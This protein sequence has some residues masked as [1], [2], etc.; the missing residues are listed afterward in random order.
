[1]RKVALLYN[2]FAGTRRRLRQTE[3]G[4]A[5]RVFREHGVEVIP[6][7]TEGPG[8]AGKQALAAIAAGADAIIC[9]GGDGTVHEAMQPL[10]SAHSRTPLGVIPLGTGNG[11]ACEMGMS[12]HPANAAWELLRFEPRRLPVG[13]IQWTAATGA[14]ESRFFLI[15]AGVGADAEMLYRLPAAQKARH[16]LCAYYWHALRLFWTHR[17]LTLEVEFLPAGAEEPRHEV[18]AQMLA[19]RIEHF[20]GLVSRL[21]PGASLERNDMQLVLFRTPRRWPILMHATAAV[22]RRVWNIPGVEVVSATEVLCR[23]LADQ[24]ALPAA[25]SHGKLASRVY[26][27]ADGELLGSPPVRLTMVPDALTLLMPPGRRN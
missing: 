18:V 14:A 12:R 4:Q 11:L 24:R 17:F 25:W 3:V 21:T 20:G 10:V 16:G 5:A 1:M 27:Q 9:C 26:A 15:S 7:A 19:G 13:R 2:P 22:L 23:P 8:S 6:A